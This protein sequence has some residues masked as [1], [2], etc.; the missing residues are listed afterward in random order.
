MNTSKLI[1]AVTSSALF[2][3]SDSNTIYKDEGTE[4]Y[5][6]HQIDSEN[7]PLPPGDA[8]G[9]VNKL[10]AVNEQIPGSVE[11]ILLSRNS[12]DTGMRIF[13]SIK[14][15]KLPITRAALCSG[16]S[17]YKYAKAFGCQ[18]FLS[19]DDEDVK[20]ALSNG[21]AAATV[22]TSNH[23]NHH[24]EQ[25]RIAFDGDA[26]LFSDESERIYKEKGLAAFNSHESDSASTPMTGGPFKQFLTSL[27]HIQSYYDVDECPIKT[28]LVTARCAPAHERVIRTLRDWKIR[29]DESLFLGGLPKGEFLKAFEADIFFDDQLPHCESARLHVATCHV[30]SG[31]ANSATIQ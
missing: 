23:S 16:A 26:V 29:V 24:S 1:I 17:P 9:L 19:T 27:H 30:P 8:F 22:I 7:T 28:A 18:L 6:K 13:N 25:L 3:L 4:A 11:V 20:R 10:L 2:E 14:H 12:A 5:V 21:M 31:I 15:H